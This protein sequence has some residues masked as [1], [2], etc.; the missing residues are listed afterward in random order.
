[1][2]QKHPTEDQNHLKKLRVCKELA[3]RKSEVDI[4]IH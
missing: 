4:V 2:K 1:M 3:K